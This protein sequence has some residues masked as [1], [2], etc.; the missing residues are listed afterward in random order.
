MANKLHKA[1]KNTTKEKEKILQT[2]LGK[3]KGKREKS[4]NIQIKGML[5]EIIEKIDND[6]KISIELLDNLETLEVDNER[7]FLAEE[8]EI[9]KNL[10]ESC[11]PM[12]RL[13][14]NNMQFVEKAIDF[15]NTPSD[16]KTKYNIFSKE[17]V[18]IDNFHCRIFI[19]ELINLYLLSNLRSVVT[20]KPLK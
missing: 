15:V 10:Y 6:S 2:N 19:L 4:G 3:Q 14:F 8:I 9:S 20:T 5:K 11:A 13:Y 12:S 18:K 1:V 7:T 17:N 16:K